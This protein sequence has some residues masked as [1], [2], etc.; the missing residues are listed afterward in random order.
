MPGIVGANS[1]FTA[2]LQAGV[3]EKFNF[4]ANRSDFE[5]STNGLQGDI[6]E[7]ADLNEPFNEQLFEVVFE[8]SVMG[9]ALRAVDPVKPQWLRVNQKF[10]DMLGYTRD[11]LLQLTSVQI[12]YPGEEHEAISHNEKLMQGEIQSYSREKRYVRKDGSVL[13]VNIWLSSVRNDAGEP[14]QIISVIQDISEQKNA[15]AALVDSEARLRAIFDNSPACMNLKDLQG[16]YI[17]A[18]KKYG[19]WW[20]MNVDDIVGKTAKE[21]HVSKQGLEALTAAEKKVLETGETHETEVTIQRECDPEP[22][23]RLLIKFP[24]K[25]T[26]GTIIGL[27]TF[28]FDITDRKKAEAELLRHRDHLQELVDNATDSLKLKAD[29]LHMALAKEKELNELQQQFVSM[30]SHEFRTPLTIIDNAAQRMKRR[31]DEGE[32][33][34]DTAQKKIEKIRGAV[35]RMTRLMESTLSAARLDDGKISIE[36]GPCSI[37]KTVEEVCARH[38]ELVTTHNIT[39]DTSRLPV[40][41]QADNCS[42]EQIFNNLL[43]NAVKYSPA[44]PNIEVAG[45]Q[46]DGYAI[47]SVRD[48]G[49]GIDGEDI[50]RIG[51][52]FFRA[53]TSTGIAGTGIGLNLTKTLVEMHGGSLDVSSAEGAGSVFTTRLPI[54]GPKHATS[55]MNSVPAVA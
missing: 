8:Q 39:F 55:D 15:K 51:E 17:F 5:N 14:I 20:N 41:I 6:L 52:K 48:Y 19:E 28:A 1:I 26:E 44:N 23:D 9:M 18:N 53:K 50:S 25:S 46:E 11:E 31:L 16:R 43:S 27:G 2:Q 34:P 12:S 21:F 45:W 29:E 4:S 40:E 10:C 54:S 38:N 33:A 13:W 30:A 3:S 47:V 37:A 7:K 36:I 24:V 32:L 22:H 49:I 42:V 35:R